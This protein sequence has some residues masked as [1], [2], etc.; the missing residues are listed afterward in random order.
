MNNSPAIS[1]T[2]AD[3]AINSAVPMLMSLS[4]VVGADDCCKVIIASR[5]NSSVFYDADGVVLERIIFG[6]GNC[7][8][9]SEGNKAVWM[10]PQNHITVTVMG[11]PIQLG[12]HCADVIGSLLFALDK[13]GGLEELPPKERECIALAAMR[14]TQA[15][16]VLAAT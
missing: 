12:Q 6:S 11:L 14:I 8:N 13:V 3:R 1:I 5:Q 7:V 4:R 9:F 15:P 16:L 2:D 10:D